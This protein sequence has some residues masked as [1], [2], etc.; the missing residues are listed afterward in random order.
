MVQSIEI[1]T[2]MLLLEINKTEERGDGLTSSISNE[3]RKRFT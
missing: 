3:K 1:Q 2:V